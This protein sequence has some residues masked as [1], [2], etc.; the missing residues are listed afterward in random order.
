MTSV[1]GTVLA[2]AFVNVRDLNSDAR[3]SGRQVVAALTQARARA[4]GT[5]GAVRVSASNNTLVAQA[6]NDCAAPAGW[7]ALPD[8]DVSLPPRTTL[9]SS[10]TVCFGSR[11][12]AQAARTLTVTDARGRSN[13]V[14]VYLGGAVKVLP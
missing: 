1:F 5:T 10:G 11:G 12:T 6:S 13:T 4:M 9:A 2:L 3:A 14:Q 8:L 7:T